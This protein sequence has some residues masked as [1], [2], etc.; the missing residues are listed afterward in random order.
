[1]YLGNDNYL[2]PTAYLGEGDNNGDAPVFEGDCVAVNWGGLTL[3]G[4]RHPD[5]PYRIGEVEGWEELPPTRVP[6]VDR[7]GWHGQFSLPVY[8]SGRV[9]MV[10]GQCASREE[11]DALLREFRD[12]LVLTDTPRLLTVAMAG[13]TL[14]AAARLTRAKAVIGRNW[15]PGI[16]PWAVEWVCPDPFRYGSPQVMYTTLPE[17]K[18]GL[19]FD[20]FTDGTDDTGVLEF[21]EAGSLGR[22]TLTNDGTA[23]AYPTFEVRGPAPQGFTIK[24]VETGRRIVSAT[25]VPPG[26]VLAINTA[27]GMATL[28]GVDRSGQLTVR[29]WAPVP[30]KSSA[31]FAFS[32]PVFTTAALVASVRPTFW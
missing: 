13:R 30:P 32:A 1:M 10:A 4:D 12:R 31:T 20:L 23:D 29:E 8:A 28:D 16:F 14:Y 3:W 9:V 6:G 11:R 22:V 21:G 24:H 18:G 15:G 25:V 17:L 19:E 7:P 26:S 2:G 5:H 27:N